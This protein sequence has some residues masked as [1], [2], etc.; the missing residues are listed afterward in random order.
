MAQHSLYIFC[1]LAFSSS[2]TFVR[3]LPDSGN[4]MHFRGRHR[5]YLTAEG[6]GVL[7]AVEILLSSIE[8]IHA[9]R[10]KEHHGI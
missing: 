4:V 9:E 3:A 6:L 1:N 2:P 10:W 7:L 5:C 8:H